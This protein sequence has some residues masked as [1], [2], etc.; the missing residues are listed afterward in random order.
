MT[1]MEVKPKKKFKFELPDTIVL[2]LIL[3]LVAAI[4]T[5]IIPAG[6]YDRVLNEATKRQIADPNSYHLVEQKPVG[7]IEMFDA[8]PQGLLSRPHNDIDVDLRCRIPPCKLYRSYRCG[9]GSAIRSLT[10][11]KKYILV[12]GLYLVSSIL[13]LRGSAETLLP[14]VPMA[15]AACI[16]LGY[17]SIA[18][19]GIILIGGA[20]GLMNSFM[21]TTLIIAQGIAE[22]PPFSGLAVRVV[23]FFLFLIVG[24]IFIYFYCRKLDKDPKL[25]PMYDADR[26]LTFKDEN[27]IPEFTPKRKLVLSTFGI[28]MITLM[29]CITIFTF[30]VAKVTTLYFIL[31][32]IIGVVGGYTPNS[33]AKEFVNGCKSMM[34]GAL[35]VGFAKSISVVMTNCMILVTITQFSSGLLD[36]LPA[37]ILSSGMMVVQAFLSVVVP[38]GSGQAAVTMPIMAPLADFIGVTRQTSVLAFTLGD[39]IIN[40]LTPTSGYFMAAIGISNISW[41]KWSKW[42]MPLCIAWIVLACIILSVCTAMKYGPF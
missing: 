36:F 41:S 20:A 5:Y 30:N 10:G 22:L 8:I 27:N 19:T 34:Y 35:I 6:E 23:S 16:A 37:S 33:F 39:G 15:V 24:G 26:S 11:K 7:I 32:L 17:D 31:A 28:G 25:S 21:S 12:F 40:L 38:S 42:Y 29:A 2:L 9:L 13:G 14:F 18:G 1:T 3:T 4:L